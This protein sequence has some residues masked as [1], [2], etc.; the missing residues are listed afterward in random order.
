MKYCV[1]YAKWM[2]IEHPCRIYQHGSDKMSGT[3]FKNTHTFVACSNT[4]PILFLKKDLKMKCNSNEV[5]N[6]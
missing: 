4:P 6:S 1:R 3:L 5:E 2:N